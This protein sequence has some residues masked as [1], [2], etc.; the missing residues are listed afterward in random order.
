MSPDQSAGQPA[1]V[2]WF[3]TVIAEYGITTVIAAET[4]AILATWC[5]IG[6]INHL[7]ARRRQRRADLA[8]CNAIWNI[9]SPRKETP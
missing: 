5:G 3:I 6:A 4:V 2:N 1:I 7:R 9:P 8:T